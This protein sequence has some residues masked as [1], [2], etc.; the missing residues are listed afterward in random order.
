MPNPEQ[1]NVY[2]S[3]LESKVEERLESE[4]TSE[5]L[6][7]VPEELMEHIKETN[8]ELYDEI[9]D[10][11]TLEATNEGF[12]L[13][14]KPQEKTWKPKLEQLLATAEGE[15]LEK[16]RAAVERQ[17]GWKFG[18]E[19]EAKTS[20]TVLNEAEGTMHIE[21]GGGLW[22]V[23][24]DQVGDQWLLKET[25]YKYSPT[26]GHSALSAA[27][28]DA[29]T[30]WKAGAMLKSGE[31]INRNPESSNEFL[32][33]FR[34]DWKKLQWI[35]PGFDTDISNSIV[36]CE[37]TSLVSDFVNRKYRE[38]LVSGA[39]KTEEDAETTTET[40][41]AVNEEVSDYLYNPEKLSADIEVAR[42][43]IEDIEYFDP[44]LAAELNAEL[45]FVIDTYTD[46]NIVENQSINNAETTG[47]P[48]IAGEALTTIFYE[49]AEE[50]DRLYPSDEP[51]TSKRSSG[52]TEVAKASGSPETPRSISTPDDFEAAMAAEVSPQLDGLADAEIGGGDNS[53]SDVAA[54]VGTG[55][56][57]GPV[58]TSYHDV[59]IGDDGSEVVTTHL[60]TKDVLKNSRIHH[61]V[62]PSEAA[63]LHVDEDK[64]GN[65]SIKATVDGV[66]KTFTWRKDKDTKE[67]SWVDETGYRLRVLDGTEFKVY[68]RPHDV[69]PAV[70]DDTA[71][72]AD[73]D[74]A[75]ETVD[76]SSTGDGSPETV[77]E[78]VDD[79]DEE[80]A[81]ETTE[82]EPEASEVAL[83]GADHQK[84]LATLDKLYKFMSVLPM[85]IGSIGNIERKLLKKKPEGMGTVTLKVEKLDVRNGVAN[86]D[87]AYVDVDS[88]RSEVRHFVGYDPAENPRYKRGIGEKVD[89]DGNGIRDSKENKEA[90][91]SLFYEQILSNN[92]NGTRPADA[93]KLRKKR[94]ET[95][96]TQVIEENQDLA[97]L[98][99][100][101][102][103]ADD[104]NRDRREDRLDD[105]V[106]EDLKALR[107]ALA[108]LEESGY[109]DGDEAIARVKKDI[110]AYKA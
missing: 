8:Q 44:E 83:E 54:G 86:L 69:A 92:V 28:F 11:F 62:G 63:P 97:K 41:K 53:A 18:H 33:P 17:V 39:V 107:A 45:S 37:P 2:E 59:E 22:P 58:T 49:I 57:A 67:M 56:E 101:R 102:D 77:D 103:R 47:D 78:D 21:I 1:H 16:K 60:P 5:R 38:S 50:H 6:E 93:E 99:A 71:D 84:T 110:D 81:V 74:A 94:A 52:P 75:V 61:F 29:K 80:A 91:R 23:T 43:N 12:K 96:K 79:T 88:G 98:I 73:E 15:A 13:V 108:S 68:G 85:D 100:K 7:V 105:R 89:V 31:L 48:E 24:I 4:L 27:L 36:M 104:R 65:V 19:T 66:E 10:S 9:M 42:L 82:G 70:V 55:V 51:S 25:D 26:S 40:E 64:L 14:E 34:V 87:L 32:N 90:V 3:T 35:N 30:I 20:V 95:F 109:F 76:T 106:D 72:E 46:A